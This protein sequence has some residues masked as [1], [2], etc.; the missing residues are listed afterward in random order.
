MTEKTVVIQPMHLLS[1]FETQDNKPWFCLSTA[2]TGPELVKPTEVIVGYAHEYFSGWP[3]SESINQ[4]YQGA[5][6]FPVVETIGKKLVKS[7][8]LKFAISRFSSN[9][10]GPSCATSLCRD[11]EANWWNRGRQ[12]LTTYSECTP[13]TRD[14]FEIDVSAAIQDWVYGRA[15]NNGFVLIGPLTNFDQFSDTAMLTNQ[16]CLTW[17]TD[18]SLTVTYYE[19]K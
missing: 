11:D 4:I 8:T 17:Y 13:I 3:C 15:V 10:G 2:G 9:A 12:G 16:Q 14:R 5:V 19:T 6:W 1:M 7:A 18:F